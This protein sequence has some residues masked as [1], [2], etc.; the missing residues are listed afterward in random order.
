MMWFFGVGVDEDEGAGRRW[1]FIR[2][3]GDQELKEM[4]DGRLVV[5]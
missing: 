2:E 1:I 5:E 3:N 4:W